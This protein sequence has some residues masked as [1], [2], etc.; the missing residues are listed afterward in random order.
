MSCCTYMILLIERDGQTL[1][2]LSFALII[3][4]GQDDKAFE[5]LFLALGLE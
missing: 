5:N 4:R 1:F 3:S 2:W